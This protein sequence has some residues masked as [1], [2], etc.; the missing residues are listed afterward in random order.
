MALYSEYLANSDV[1]EADQGSLEQSDTQRDAVRQ[2]RGRWRKGQKARN[3][4]L[5]HLEGQI[6]GNLSTIR[7]LLC[8]LK[9]LFLLLL[10]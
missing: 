6:A 7:K 1:A 2:V 10:F 9:F 8:L 3:F 5:R 4:K